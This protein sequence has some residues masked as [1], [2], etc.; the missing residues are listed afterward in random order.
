[1]GVWGGEKYIIQ[2]YPFFSVVLNVA[3]GHASRGFP[4]STRGLPIFESSLPIPSVLGKPPNA[5]LSH[6][7][8]TPS[9]SS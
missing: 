9:T 5:A 4:A 1:M 2:S 8:G 3:P 6:S 7:S